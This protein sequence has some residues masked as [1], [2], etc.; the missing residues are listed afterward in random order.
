MITISRFG[1]S[2]SSIL[3]NTVRDSTSDVKIRIEVVIFVVSDVIRVSIPR[4]EKYCF[5]LF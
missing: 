3:A 1:P 2:G 4:R 5:V